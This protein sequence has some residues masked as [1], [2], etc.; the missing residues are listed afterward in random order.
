M[1]QVEKNFYENKKNINARCT[2][3]K[4]KTTTKAK[5]KK[6]AY[7]L[8][9]FVLGF[10]LFLNSCAYEAYPNDIFF[11]KTQASGNADATSWEDASDF[12]T[13]ITKASNSS[14][15]KIIFLEKGLHRVDEKMK[16]RAFQ[17]QSG[18][19]VY[20][21]FDSNNPNL[22]K[23]LATNYKNY[24]LKIAFD[25]QD[26]RL[27]RDLTVTKLARMANTTSGTIVEMRDLKDEVL[28]DGIVFEN[29][30][31][32]NYTSGAVWASNSKVKFKNIIFRNLQAKYASGV[33]AKDSELDFENCEFNNNKAN[34]YGSLAVKKSKLKIKNSTFSS[35]TAN[36]GAAIYS[37]DSQAQIINSEFLRNTA[38]SNPASIGEM[39]DAIGTIYSNRS[40]IKIEN[41][42]FKNNNAKN[43]ASIYNRYAQLE[44]VNSKFSNNSVD[45]DPNPQNGRN[46]GGAIFSENSDLIITNSNFDNNKSARG[47]AV[48]S[49]SDTKINLTNNIFENNESYFG[50]ALY[51]GSSKDFSLSSL[52]F[53]DNLAKGSGGAIYSTQNKKSI[54]KNSTFSKNKAK[55]AGG[56]FSYQD[57]ISFVNLSVFKNTAQE[58]AGGIL[59]K[60]ENGTIGYTPDAK[61]INS[62]IYD[63]IANN[64]KNE[65]AKVQN[66]GI[67]K[68]VTNLQIKHSLVNE[69]S[70]SNANELSVAKFDDDKNNRSF[71]KIDISKNSGD[72]NITNIDPL[73]SFDQSK[74]IYKFDANSGL[75]NAGSENLYQQTTG[76]NLNSAKD[77][78]GNPRLFGTEIDIGAFELQN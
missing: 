2:K 66:I 27:G 19:K 9:I 77:Q 14:G 17:L 42:L 55:F 44:V 68:N 73:I 5:I 50:G 56:I 28:F 16:N 21:G 53:I 58:Q 8:K 26:S 47:G 1:L 64:S 76:E 67:S 36:Y 29:N 22:K 54:I 31:N 78:L 75:R 18:V 63:N 12:Q 35:N 34:F 65:T 41:S 43:G 69:D 52:A 37:E 71:E 48:Y 45:T 3:T 13:A 32:L 57:N 72:K 10:T 51:L 24:K 61:I 11:A 46:G 40:K 6:S 4:T 33:Y 39:Y 59:I 15:K 70:N 23:Y 60:T 7:F 20:G 30:S 74:K 38:N 49:F 62:V 25:A